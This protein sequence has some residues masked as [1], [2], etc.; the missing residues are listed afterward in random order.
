MMLE[1]A[2]KEQLKQDFE[3]WWNHD[4]KRPIIQVNL[5]STEPLP[6]S[7]GQLLKM[8]YDP[9]ISV[10]NVANAY[11]ENF[12]NSIYL[13]DAFPVYYQRVTGILGAFLGQQWDISE[14]NATVWYKELNK[15]LAEIHP[16]FDPSFWFYQRTKDLLKAF[17]DVFGDDVALGI[18]D[19]GGM[20]DIVESMRGANNSLM[21]LYDEPDE[22]LR[23]R[24]DIYAA[25]EKILT[26]MMDILKD[27]PKL[28]YTGWITMLSQKPFYI[29]QCDFCCM[30]SAKQFDQFVKGTLEKESQLVERSFYHLDGPG[31]VRHLDTILQCGFDG[32]QWVQGA[33]AESLDSGKWDDIFRKVRGSGKLLQVFISSAEDLKSIDHIVNVLD[34]DAS[35][36]AFICYGRNEDRPIFEQYLTK[37]NVPF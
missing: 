17:S 26:E 36:L 11:G 14:E 18:P 22:V 30:I 34:G 4:L 25:F 37:Y 33:G 23:L 35:G 24:N 8:C 5:D 10:Q 9:S 12:K 13:G 3:A 31:A 1:N 29:S 21:D 20:M 32:I 28:G 27:K 16:E 7:R 19:L 15:S 2:K 6:Y